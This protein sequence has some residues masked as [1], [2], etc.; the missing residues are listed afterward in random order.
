MNSIHDKLIEAIKKED[1]Q[2]F[3]NYMKYHGEVFYSPTLY[4]QVLIANIKN[5]ESMDFFGFMLKSLHKVKSLKSKVGLQ[6]SN[7]V[8]ESAIDC[9]QR[10]KYNKVKSFVSKKTF[11]ERNVLSPYSMYG[12]DF[13]DEFQKIL[14]NYKSTYWHDFLNNQIGSVE[15]HYLDLV[16]T[17]LNSPKIA[18]DVMVS[19]ILNDKKEMIDYLFQSVD[20]KELDISSILK[21]RYPA[22]L[23]K[24]GDTQTL[25]TRMSNKYPMAPYYMEKHKAFSLYQ[26][27]EE[28]MPEKTNTKK[29]KL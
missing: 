19:S 1:K 26:N 10:D 28:Q 7:Q 2:G 4:K 20:I 9:N 13:L 23:D 3:L 14:P 18:S 12:K 29:I 11:Y 17:H 27:L 21:S 25:L 8:L 24:L 5:N 16:L 22:H 6:I 15:A